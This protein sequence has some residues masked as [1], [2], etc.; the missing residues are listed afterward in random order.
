MP[1]IASIRT[2]YSKILTFLASMIWQAKIVAM[3]TI[4]FF[5][6]ILTSAYI[7]IFTNYLKEYFIIYGIIT[8]VGLL[9]LIYK[10]SLFKNVKLEI[11]TYFLVNVSIISF[12][13]LLFFL[14]LYHAPV[15]RDWDAWVVHLTLGKSIYVSGQIPNNIFNLGYPAAVTPIFIPIIYALFSSFSIGQLFYTILPLFFTILFLLTTYL[16]SQEL[17]SGYLKDYVLPGISML[18]SP[19]FIAILLGY[20][21]DPDLYFFC[22]FYIAFYFALKA[23][24]S[25]AKGYLL[26]EGMCLSLGLFT[27]TIGI[28]LI[29]AVIS[30]NVLYLKTKFAKFLSVA[31]L[32]LPFF[33][34][35]LVQFLT[36]GKYNPYLLLYQFGLVFLL[37]FIIRYSFSIKA[38]N[39]KIRNLSILLI[40]LIISLGYFL[41][42]IINQGIWFYGIILPPDLRSLYIFMTNN[43]WGTAQ[44]SSISF[45]RIDTVILNYSFLPTILLSSLGFIYLLYKKEMRAKVLPLVAIIGISFIMIMNL[46][47]QLYFPGIALDLSFI[48]RYIE[49][50]PLL[51]ILSAYGFLEIIKML[52]IQASRSTKITSY[53][54]IFSS[55]LIIVL[56]L[57][58]NYW[59]YVTKSLSGIIQL[60]YILKKR[61]PPMDFVLSACIVFAGIFMYYVLA[62]IEKM[63]KARTIM[64]CLLLFIIL[65]SFVTTASI[66]QNPI[67]EALSSN[68]NEDTFFLP[69]WVQ[70]INY[71]NSTNT[72]N[73]TIVTFNTPY[74]PF[75][76]NQKIIDLDT[77]FGFATFL[78][79]V[80][81]SNYENA[82]TNLLNSNITYFLMPLASSPQMVEINALSKQCP[83]INEIYQ[84]PQFV[85]VKTFE[86][87]CLI[88][89]MNDS[90]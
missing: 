41:F 6:L 87:Y 8:I 65:A 90:Q 39:L 13:I 85:V 77:L 74:L 61:I 32:S 80:N 35:L 79:M 60:E 69:E 66:L 56:L 16:I 18:L 5:I 36:S 22:F 37:Y 27:Y 64:P 55:L 76:A 49:I 51:C 57:N 89:L 58:A 75:F 28:A 29:P 25:G 42:Y 71:L 38:A 63:K 2:I 88:Q 83:F 48:R 26:L 72:E 84:N 30:F 3:T 44:I 17:F 46:Y 4:W 53:F 9:I 81:N 10:K 43:L 15:S 70:I 12:T 62:K 19:L 11:N 14:L 34:Y 50:L 47:P 7:G 33:A 20:A 23:N 78:T 73:S 1:L 52:K 68:N 82:I 40:P 24:N 86:T 21:Y 31:L 45:I 59:P 54:L 67:H